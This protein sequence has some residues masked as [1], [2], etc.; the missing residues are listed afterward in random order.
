MAGVDDH[1]AV[2]GEVLTA[3]KW[4][5]MLNDLPFLADDQTFTGNI[6]LD[7]NDNAVALSIDTEATTA[8]GVEYQQG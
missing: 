3:K 7:Q 8:N 6:T 5:D 1:S 4:N 2:D